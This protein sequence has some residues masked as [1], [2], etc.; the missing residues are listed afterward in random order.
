LNPNALTLPIVI[1]LIAIL[2]ITLSIR[3]LRTPQRAPHA[4]RRRITER[5]LLTLVILVCVFL[6]GSTIYNAAAHRYYRAIYPAPG[7]IYS[8]NGHDMHLYCTG[9][10]SPTL[11]LEAGGGNDSL[12]W[13]KV[14][15]EL[16]KITRVCS[17][18]RAGF[19]WST[20][21]P[22]PRDA[23]TIAGELHALLRQAGIQGPIVLMGHSRAG[24]YIRAYNQLY[25]EQVKGLVFVDSSVFLYWDRMSPELRA[26]NSY[27]KPFYYS[28]VAMAALGLHRVEGACSPNPGFDEATGTRIAQLECGKNGSPVF[29][30]YETTRQSSEET[31]HTGPYGDLPILI[32]SRDAELERQNSG[33]PAKLALEQSVFWEQEQESFKR[34]STHS[35][36]IIAKGSG[37]PIQYERADLVNKEVAIFI[38][39]IRNHELRTDYGST[40]RE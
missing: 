10:G 39:Q 17:Y 24:M 34:L 26:A 28:L 5:V 19:G 3:R 1:V 31:I 37:H 36:R 32:F 22:P 20:P 6:A 29:Q 21:Q 9:E 13:T 38:Q 27:S 18:D 14:Q 33:L 11:V 12:T 4:K 40:T 35:R 25:P 7:K 30:E 2:I 15:P 23:N 8:V 16:S